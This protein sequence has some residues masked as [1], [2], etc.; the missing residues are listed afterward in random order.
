MT[1]LDNECQRFL[2]ELRL[3]LSPTT[4]VRKKNELEGFVRHLETARKHYA[5][6]KKQDIE[7]YLLALPRTKARRQQIVCTLRAFYRFLRFD[8]SVNPASDI[9]FLPAK[10]KRLPHVPG[11]AA[12]ITSIARLSD[13]QTE[14]ALRNRV[15]AELAYGSGLRRAELRRLDI[16]DIDLEDSSAH[17]AGKGGK[18]RVVPL[19]AK[20]VELIRG[21][22]EVRRAYRG[23][24]LA[25]CR[26]RRLGLQGVYDVFREKA[27]IRPH[28][29]RHACATHMLKNG[30][31]L[32]II[33]ELLGHSRLTTAQIYTHISKDE[34][35]AVIQRMHPRRTSR[36]LP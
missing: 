36:F 13:E 18:D 5:A 12:V 8:P 30:C 21:Y 6:V 31:N 22:L 19:T 32:R 11:K 16:E 17:I 25:S 7:R 28:L 35:R 27:G 29:M 4:Y 3:C 34:L 23:P 10:E 26:G 2:T 33:Q 15:M 9:T 14:I 20:A 1:T 24:L